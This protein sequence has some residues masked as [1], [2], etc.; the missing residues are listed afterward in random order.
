MTRTTR[1]QAARG[2][3]RPETL[4][5]FIRDRARAATA[6]WEDAKNAFTE[7]FATN[8]SHAIEWNAKEVVKAQSAH[9][10]WNA[11]WKVAEREGGAAA[12]AWA[13]E[14]AEREVDGF[15]GSN[16]TCPWHNAMRRTEA[17]TF[18]DLLRRAVRELEEV[19]EEAKR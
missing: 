6:A 3:A 8:P 17:E 4:E 19:A 2:H 15:F 1:H 16:S 11:T 13:R 7:A 9:I 18:H 14:S 5:E 12:I 10:W